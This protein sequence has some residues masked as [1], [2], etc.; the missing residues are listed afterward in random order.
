MSYSLPNTTI[1]SWLLA[2]PSKAGHV[3]LACVKSSAVAGG[4]RTVA[5]FVDIYAIIGIDTAVVLLVVVSVVLVVV[6]LLVVV[7]FVLTVVVVLMGVV[8][9]IIHLVVVIYVV[10][11]F[12]VVHHAGWCCCCGS[13]YGQGHIVVVGLLAVMHRCSSVRSVISLFKAHLTG[14]VGLLAIN[15]YGVV[16]F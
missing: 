5:G 3:H 8:L 6:V 9:V 1:A 2:W 4:V 11:L 14:N 10:L 16:R 12:V 7:V 13:A 15:E